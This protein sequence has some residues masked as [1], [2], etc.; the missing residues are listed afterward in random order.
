MYLMSKGMVKMNRRDFEEAVARSGLNPYARFI[1]MTYASFADWKE[2][3]PEVWPGMK[4]VAR[5]TGIHRDTVKDYVDALVTD[6]WLIP[7]RKHG[8]AQGYIMAEGCLVTRQLM[9]TRGHNNL[10][11]K[12]LVVPNPMPSGADDE[13]LVVPSPMPSDQALITK[14]NHIEEPKE[15]PIAVASAPAPPFDTEQED[16]MTLQEALKTLDPPLDKNEREKVRV[17]RKD[18]KSADDVLRLLKIDREEGEW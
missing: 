12:C 13:C 2:V 11:S 17:W 6:G 7:A 10:R 1:L 4:E 18:G 9:K 15:E 16:E 8:R 5:I 3:D 14:S